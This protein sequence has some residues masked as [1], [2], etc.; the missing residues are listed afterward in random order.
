VAGKQLAD[1]RWVKKKMTFEDLCVR[2]EII[3]KE[4]TLHLI[5]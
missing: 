4:Q 5:V 3:K 2:M 1:S